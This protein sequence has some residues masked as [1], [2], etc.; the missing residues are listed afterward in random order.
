ML[1]IFSIL[2]KPNFSKKINK[3]FEFFEKILD[4]Y[5]LKCY[6]K[7]WKNQGKIL[8]SYILEKELEII[9]KLFRKKLEIL[10]KQLSNNISKRV[11]HRM[12]K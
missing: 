1:N 3:N 11:F 6:Q 4:K 2:S 7:T 10:P 12:L 8:E 5:I 9:L